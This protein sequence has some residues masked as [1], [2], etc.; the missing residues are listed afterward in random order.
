MKIAA[1]I[2]SVLI[3]FAGIA[4]KCFDDLKLTKPDDLTLI[5]ELDLLGSKNIGCIVDVD[6]LVSTEICGTTGGFEFC[7]SIIDEKVVTVY[8]D[9]GLCFSEDNF[10]VD[11][12][13]TK[14][15]YEQDACNNFMLRNISD[16][17]SEKTFTELSIFDVSKYSSYEYKVYDLVNNSY[18]TYPS[19]LNDTIILPDGHYEIELKLLGVEGRVNQFEDI[20]STTFGIEVDPVIVSDSICQG[21]FYVF[22][23]QEIYEEGE[24]EFTFTNG[25]GCD[26][27]VNLSLSFKIDGCTLTGLENERSRVSIFPQ[28]AT[29]FIFLKA[30]NEQ[31]V[32]I[33]T[34]Q[35]IIVR[36]VDLLKGDNKIDIQDLAS[37]VYIVMF[38]KAVEKLIV[39]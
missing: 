10:Y 15:S 25:N 32:N 29:D 11:I 16:P 38:G 9:D 13:D 6:E 3:G 23:D 34:T 35:G 21:E 30:L 12:V 39:K 27:I 1:L 36:T 4:Q 19:Q 8:G 33:T 24:F 18:A 5:G 37:G 31:V 26:S 14:F 28:P 22:G 2:L 7:E 20:T 17:V